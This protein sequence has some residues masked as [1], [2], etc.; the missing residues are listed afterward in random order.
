MRLS[1]LILFAIILLI[2]LNDFAVDAKKS[3]KTTKPS[4]PPPPPIPEKEIDSNSEPIV[5]SEKRLKTTKKRGTKDWNSLKISDLE[6]EWEED[7]NQEELEEEFERQQQINQRLKEE[8]GRKNPEDMVDINDPESLRRVRY[9]Y[10]LPFYLS[11][12]I[13]ITI[14]IP[15]IVS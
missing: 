13:N 14:I 12:V 4:K 8:E 10:Y 15:Y 1:I 9:N 7:D 3:K 11:I 5:K 6:K 2:C